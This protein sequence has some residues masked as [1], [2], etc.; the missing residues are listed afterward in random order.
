MAN[1]LLFLFCCGSNVLFTW[2][3]E[4]LLN[5]EGPVI[6]WKSFR[7]EFDFI[8][9]LTIFLREPLS[10]NF[11]EGCKMD[12]VHPRTDKCPGDRRLLSMAPLVSTYPWPSHTLWF[13]RVSISQCSKHWEHLWWLLGYTCVEEKWKAWSAVSKIRREKKVKFLVVP[14]SGWENQWL[15]CLSMTF[16]EIK[17][18]LWASY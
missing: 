10:K 11:H 3:L 9:Y 15:K 8:G 1:T 12:Y 17:Y 6:A 2:Y 5:L 13:Y 18:E 14:I 16:D 4:G 7:M